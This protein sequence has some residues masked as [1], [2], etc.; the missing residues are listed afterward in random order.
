LV[1]PL[2]DKARHEA[3]AKAERLDAACALM[4]A[5]TEEECQIFYARLETRLAN[6]ME[7]TSTTATGTL[8]M[9]VGL[10][11][12]IEPIVEPREERPEAIKPITRAPELPFIAAKR[13]AEAAWERDY[14]SHLMVLED[15]CVTRAAKRAGVDRRNFRTLLQRSGLRP[16][17][18]KSKKKE[19]DQKY[20]DQILKILDEHPHGLRTWEIAEKTQ[21]TLNNAFGTLK[22]LARQDRVARHGKR[23]NTLWAL[24]GVLPAARVETIPAA[25]VAVLSKATSA[26][27]ARR[28]RDEISELMRAVGKPPSASALNRAISRLVSSGVLACHGAN[29]HGAMYV[30]TP[31]GDA[32]ELN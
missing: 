10:I 7:T 13:L 9:K 26:M 4:E 22:S 6:F 28:L 29:E 3:L 5:L 30:L 21:Q 24:P 25:A 15:G 16:R 31:K 8:D 12:P 19:P 18:V 1:T 11:E 32:A 14:L 23:Y 20:T 27:D 2:S 17:G